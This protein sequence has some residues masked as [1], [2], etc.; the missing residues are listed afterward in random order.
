MSARELAEDLDLNARTGRYSDTLRLLQ[1][2]Q[3]DSDE[4]GH[5]VDE[6]GSL[7]YSRVVLTPDS[8]EHDT[9]TLFSLG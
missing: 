5:E 2:L 7:T 8:D 9:D 3:R 4:L 6:L 1:T